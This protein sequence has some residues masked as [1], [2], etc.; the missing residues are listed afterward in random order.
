MTVADTASRERGIDIVAEREAGTL[1]IEVKGF[2]EPRL[3]RSPQGQREEEGSSQRAGH[4]LVR[5]GG[6]RSDADMVP[7]A[8]GPAGYCI[9]GFPEIPR[10]LPEKPPNHWRDAGSNYGGCQ[11]RRC[12]TGKAKVNTNYALFSI[13]ERFCAKLI[14]NAFGSRRT[15]SL[16]ADAIVTCLPNMLICRR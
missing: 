8:A 7:D 15:E 12:H 10:P 4:G 11:G 9:A 6:S 3:R 14:L 5:P 1:A 2:P 13:P 16:D